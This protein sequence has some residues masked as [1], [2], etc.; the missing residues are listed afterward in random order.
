MPHD[1][2]HIFVSYSHD[3][4]ERTAP[5][6]K[7]LEARGYSLWLDHAQL[8][9]GDNLTEEI[10]R[11][12]QDSVAFI[13]FVGLHYFRNGRYTRREY[14]GA[15]ALAHSSP[16]WRTIIVRLDQN[17]EIPPMSMDRLRIE[18][19]GPEQA[20]DDIATALDRFGAVDGI[21]Y[22]DRAAE[23][24]SNWHPLEIKTLN[25]RDLRL[26]ARGLLAQ[27]LD[28]LRQPGDQ[29]EFEIELGHKRTIRLSSLRTIVEDTGTR[30]ELESQLRQIEV[31]QRHIEKVRKKLIEGLLGRFE[32]DYEMLLEE[33]EEKSE[34]THQTLRRHLEGLAE[35]I[36]MRTV[37]GDR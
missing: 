26:V 37:L 13:A 12:L 3:D 28:K 6:C 21:A 19:T 25:E 34:Q 1:R 9:P 33:H 32:V 22:S 7:A 30:L 24:E 16:S 14:Y 2:G 18:Y 27:R 35:S 17:A 10:D 8:R 15:S 31:S 4:A 23:P 5:V 29:I 36:Q 20:A 11:A